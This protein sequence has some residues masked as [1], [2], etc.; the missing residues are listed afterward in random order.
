[1]TPEE[2]TDALL[3]A[4]GRGEMLDSADPAVR[5]LAVLLDDVDQRRSS[6]SMTPST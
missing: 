5:L 2:E 1:M 4:L 3:D 6:V